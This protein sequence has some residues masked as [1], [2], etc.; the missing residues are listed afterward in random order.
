MRST[1]LVDFLLGAI[2]AFCLCT[3]NKRIPEETTLIDTV[4]IPVQGGGTIP[5]I[6]DTIYLE[7]TSIV[8]KAD[9]QAVNSYNGFFEDSLIKIKV[10]GFL[11][12]KQN[13]IDS[14]Q[15]QYNLQLPT[16]RERI[17]PLK[18]STYFTL[19][20]TTN[21]SR[22]GLGIGVIQTNNKIIYG[23][24]VDPIIGTVSASL[25]IKIK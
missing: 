6:H 21:F 24:S 1:F 20:P 9:S 22:V 12:L 16:I 19:S 4:Y 17:I 2:C 15:L 11:G 18:K 14:F 3:C 13:T 10:K 25:G 7:S 23:L 5:A 8:A